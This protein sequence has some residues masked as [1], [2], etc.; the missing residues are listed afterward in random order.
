MPRAGLSRVLIGATML[1]VMSLLTLGLTR[2]YASLPA[3]ERS[4]VLLRPAYAPASLVIVPAH[5]HGA[6]K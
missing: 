6:I 2:A 1:P 5:E 4:A 3:S